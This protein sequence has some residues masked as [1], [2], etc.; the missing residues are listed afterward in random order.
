[1]CLYHVFVCSLSQQAG[2]A[3]C[4]ESSLR[5]AAAVGGAGRDRDEE[6]E[7]DVT[8]PIVACC[9]RMSTWCLFIL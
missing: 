5:A 1:M 9:E 2:G 3:V 6:D 4:M 7:R 8:A